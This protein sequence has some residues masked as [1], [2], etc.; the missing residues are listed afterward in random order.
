MSLT[1]DA[2]AVGGR[3]TGAAQSVNAGS[4]GI[5]IDDTGIPVT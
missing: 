5:G 3:T 1:V 2:S 4:V